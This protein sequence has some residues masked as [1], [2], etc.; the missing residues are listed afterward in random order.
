VGWVFRDRD[1]GVTPMDARRTEEVG[2]HTISPFLW[3]NDNAE[4]AVN[5]YVSVVDDARVTETTRYLEGSPGPVGQVMTMSFELRG[6]EFIALNGGPQFS[7]TPA[8]SF[9]V[10]CEDQQEV[11]RLWDALSDGGEKGQ[12]GWLQDRYGVSWQIVPRSLNE[13]LRGGGDEVRAQRVMAAML[14]MDKIEIKP[15]QDAYDAA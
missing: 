9:L 14:K 6:Q 2:M 12:C 7:F 13:L 5:T 4:E 15:L 1:D 11:D 3:F 8:I 10:Y